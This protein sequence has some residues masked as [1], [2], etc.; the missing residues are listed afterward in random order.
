MY[1][2]ISG[3]PKRNNFKTSKNNKRILSDYLGQ[4]GKIQIFYNVN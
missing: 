4:W 1:N 3:K 2:A